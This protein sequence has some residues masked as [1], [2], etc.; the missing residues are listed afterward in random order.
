MSQED[1]TRHCLRPLPRKS[2]SAMPQS[3]QLLIT[4]LDL[5][6]D[7]LE[8]LQQCADGLTAQEISDENFINLQTI[9]HQIKL[10][11]KKLRAANKHHLVSIA[12]RCDLVD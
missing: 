10:L 5:T 2:L 11:I 9:G 1:L 7:D 12:H 8:V 3:T 6:D 4:E